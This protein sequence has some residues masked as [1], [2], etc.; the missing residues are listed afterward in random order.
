MRQRVELT[1]ADANA[2]GSLAILLWHYRKNYLDAQ[3]QFVRAVALDP[4]N[5]NNVGNYAGFLLA[6]ADMNAAGK[7]ILEAWSLAFVE[8]T[9]ITAEVAF[10]RCIWLK[11]QGKTD[12]TSLAYLKHLF[13]MG[14]ER[15]DWRF[16]DVLEKIDGKVSA[17]DV[18]FYTALSEGILDSAKVEHLITFDRWKKVKPRPLSKE[19]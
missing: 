18:Q 5:P 3:K 7:Q 8:K 4:Q 9:Q 13:G 12:S 14:Y 11:L 15:D 16:D 17:R 6:Q 2:V 10:Y 1:K 19:I